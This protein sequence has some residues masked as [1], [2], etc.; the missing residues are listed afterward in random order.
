ML[1]IFL[2]FAASA[3]SRFA[4]FFTPTIVQG[5]GRNRALQ[6]LSET[7]NVLVEAIRGFAAVLDVFA[8]DIDALVKILRRHTDG[9]GDA[10]GVAA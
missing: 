4:S 2:R 9:H 8:E 10:A 6:S 5:N 7:V 3:L 1:S